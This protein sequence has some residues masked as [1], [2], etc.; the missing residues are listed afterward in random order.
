MTDKQLLSLIG[1]ISHACTYTFQGMREPPGS[2]LSYM[3]PLNSK[4]IA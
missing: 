2:L 4:A 1:L 3:C